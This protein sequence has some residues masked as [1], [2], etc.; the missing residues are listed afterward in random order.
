MVKI[1]LY[2]CVTIGKNKLINLD[3]NKNKNTLILVCKICILHFL[4]I[5][6]FPLLRSL[7]HMHTTNPIL[8]FQSKIFS[9]LLHSSLLLHMHTT[10][11]ILHFQ[12]KVFS[13]L[14]LFSFT[15]FAYYKSF[16]T[17]LTR[18]KNLQCMLDGQSINW[19]FL[20]W[21]NL[22]FWKIDILKICV[23]VFCKMCFVFPAKFDHLKV[24]AE[25]LID[26]WSI[27]CQHLRCEPKVLPTR[28]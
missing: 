15:T 27:I 24:W 28:L 3:D 9:L 17:F 10:N 5:E 25:S 11:P 26:R 19:Y 8:H 13:L 16:N 12:C 2:K 21:R 1:S 23:F 20:S 18:Q 14:L 7:L 4:S 22:M 6:F